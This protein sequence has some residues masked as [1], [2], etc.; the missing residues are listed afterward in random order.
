MRVCI[1]VEKEAGEMGK[2]SESDK[3]SLCLSEG[4]GFIVDPVRIEIP[5]MQCMSQCACLCATMRLRG[6]RGFEKVVDTLRGTKQ[7]IIQPV[8]TP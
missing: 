6:P 8:L 7:S 4:E 1:V 5:R 3:G 2:Q